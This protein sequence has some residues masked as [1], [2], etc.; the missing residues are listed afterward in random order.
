MHNGSVLGPVL[1]LLFTNDMT[2]IFDD[3]LTCILFA[4][5]VKMYS[6]IDGTFASPLTKAIDFLSAWSQEWQM[7][8]LF[9]WL[10]KVYMLDMTVQMKNI[11]WKM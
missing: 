3:S 9:L 8:L 11:K 2:E 6:M 5:D 4:D 1:F 10:Y 7:Q